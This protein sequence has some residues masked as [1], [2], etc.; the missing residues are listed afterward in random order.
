MKRSSEL[1]RVEALRRRFTAAEDPA[2]KLGIGD[3]AAV[4]D[5][6]APLGA[7][8]WTVDA[9]VEGTHFRRDWLSWEDVGWRSFVA[10]ASDLSAMGASAIGALSALVLAPDFDDAMLDALT[11]GQAAAARVVGAPIVGGNL[12]RGGETSI[13]TTVLGTAK[14][15]ITRGGARPGHGVFIAGSLGMAAAGLALLAAAVDAPEEASAC[16]AAWR[17]PSSLAGS[18]RGL[19]GVASA[20]I[21]VSDGLGHD[22]GQL[23]RASRVSLVLEESALRELASP[24]LVAAAEVLGRDPLELMLHGGED[25]ALVATADEELLGF[26]QIGTVEE[27]AGELRLLQKDGTTRHVEARGFDHFAS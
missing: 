22:L 3:D 23:A 6:A 8:V 7:V 4:L 12:A 19:A 26:T 20:A 17:R 1:E 11:A 9:Q 21:D 27:G 2:V 15:P 5:L 16:V 24:A 13:T 14:A 25:Y 18:G 10:A